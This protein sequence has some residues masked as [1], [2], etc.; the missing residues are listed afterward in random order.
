[1]KLITIEGIEKK[2]KLSRTTISRMEVEGEF[3]KRIKIGAA[4]RWV[5]EEIDIWLEGLRKE[6]S[7]VS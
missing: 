5:E 6:K 7:D 2:L 3:P 4:V 1:M